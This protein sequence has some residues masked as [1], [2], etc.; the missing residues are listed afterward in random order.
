VYLVGTEFAPG[1]Y[2]VLGY[3]AR[4]DEN[5]EIID[6]DITDDCPSIAVVHDTDAYIEI[7]GAAT[8]IQL[9]HPLD[10]VARGCEDGVFLVGLDI[11]PGQYR[12]LPR[13]TGSYW[14]RLDGDLEIIDNDISDGQLIVNVRQGDFALKI[15]GTLQPIG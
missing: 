14:A 4:L 10:P 5:Q 15:D 9:D 11:Q 6:N 7:N 8:P 12:V 1:A 13:S 3:W 2:R